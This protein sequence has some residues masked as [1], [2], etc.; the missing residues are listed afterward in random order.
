MD[1]GALNISITTA[2]QDRTEN[3]LAQCQRLLGTGVFSRQQG[4]IDYLIQRMAEGEFLNNVSADETIAHITSRVNI[5]LVSLEHGYGFEKEHWEDMQR[6]YECAMRNI[7]NDAL[8]ITFEE[9]YESVQEKLF[10]Y[11]NEYARLPV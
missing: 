5:A 1:N 3:L 10:V 6:N 11:A 7:D 4:Y 2:Q 8:K 9:W